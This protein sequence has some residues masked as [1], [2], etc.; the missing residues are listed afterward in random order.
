V[1]VIHNGNYVGTQLQCILCKCVYEI[2]SG[3]SPDD[4]MRIVLKDKTVYRAWFECPQCWNLN[5]M[6]PVEVD[7]ESDSR[8]EQDALVAN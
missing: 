2:Q 5:V 3:D 6:P 4:L 1:K 7:A 8:R